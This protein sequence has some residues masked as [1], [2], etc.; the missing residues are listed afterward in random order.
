MSL[1]V[2]D[3]QLESNRLIDGLRARGLSVATVGSFGLTGQF[4]PDVVRRVDERHSGPWVF[5]TMDLTIVEDYPR[6]DWDRYA[7]AWISVHQ[8]LAGAAFEESK[9]NV[10]HR[11]A[12]EIV[13]QARGDHHTYTTKRHLK[14]RPSLVSQV[15]RR[16]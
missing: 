10:V 3:E 12:H 2:L 11:H 9:V 13:E 4:D 1:L 6:F 7:I 16:L 14:A 8:G 5:V 15:K